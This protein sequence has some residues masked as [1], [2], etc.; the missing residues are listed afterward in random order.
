MLHNRN[1][2][3][4]AAA[5]TLLCLTG[6]YLAASTVGAIGRSRKELSPELLTGLAPS[7][8]S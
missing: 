3:W 8:W 7:I 6:I 1:L 5:K 2:R 4:T